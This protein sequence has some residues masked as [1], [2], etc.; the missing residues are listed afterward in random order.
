MRFASMGPITVPDPLHGTPR[1]ISVVDD[2]WI[3]LGGAG[4]STSLPA[5]R[6]FYERLAKAADEGAT[7]T[8]LAA[9]TGD[10]S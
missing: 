4:Y 3:H 6:D 1:R 7:L 9:N 2:S 5:M 8:T 10:P